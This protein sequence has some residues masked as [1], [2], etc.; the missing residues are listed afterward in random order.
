MDS[1]KST[2]K[3][4]DIQLY[5]MYIIFSHVKYNVLYFQMLNKTFLNKHYI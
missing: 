2:E 1:G 5:K 4:E 3:A